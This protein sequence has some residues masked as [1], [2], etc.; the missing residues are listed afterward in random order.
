MLESLSV[1]TVPRCFS[2]R[3][4]RKRSGEDKRRKKSTKEGIEKNLR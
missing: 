3:R 1:K 4:S 2:R